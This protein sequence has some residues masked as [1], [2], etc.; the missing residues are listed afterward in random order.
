MPRPPPGPPDDLAGVDRL[1]SRARRQRR[2]VNGDD[3]DD[4]RG[5]ASASTWVDED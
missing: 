4:A 3:D 2:A 1:L 5:R